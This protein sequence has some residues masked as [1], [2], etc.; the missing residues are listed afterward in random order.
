M[1]K[2]KALGAEDGDPTFALASFILSSVVADGK[3]DER[4]YLLMYPA[5]TQLF[6]NDF[7]LATV[8]SVIEADA[9]SKKAVK[10]YTEELMKLLADADESLIEDVIV[11]CLC[12]VAMDGKVSLKEK[13]YIKRLCNA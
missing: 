10:A 2:L 5:L 9:A 8:K 12:V 11:I 4:E 13:K 1:L 7:D 6:G 3:I